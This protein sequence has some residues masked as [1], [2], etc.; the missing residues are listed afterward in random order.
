MRNF[1]FLTSAQPFADLAL[2]LLRWFVGV[3]LIWG[4]MDNVGGSERMGALLNPLGDHEFSGPRWVATVTGY[5]QLAIG[6]AFV[7]GL[8]TRWA[9]ILCAILFAIA[10]ARLD[11]VG[12][13]RG[14]FPSGCLVVMVLY[15]GTH[16]AGRFSVDAALRANEL[17]RATGNVRLR[18]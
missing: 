10:I 4:V 5:L 15:L 8:F 1:A 13:M 17:P 9:G 14:I 12:G 16:G 3:Y 2:L 18:K 7:L 11:H 6:V